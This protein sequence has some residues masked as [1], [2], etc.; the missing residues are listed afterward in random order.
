MDQKPPKYPASLSELASGSNIY[1]KEIPCDP[2]NVSPYVYV[3][4]RGT[5]VL[6]YTLRACLENKSDPGG[7]IDIPGCPDLGIKKTEP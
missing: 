5:D 2:K 1:M 3:Y 4:Q 7:E 6:T